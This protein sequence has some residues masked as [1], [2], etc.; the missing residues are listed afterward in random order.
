MKFKKTALLICAIIMVMVTSTL[1]FA[2]DKTD[3]GDFAAPTYADVYVT[4]GTMSKLL[5]RQSSIAFSDYTE[6]D[7]LR[8]VTVSVNT[9]KSY[10][11]FYGYGASLTH[12]SA[13]LLTQEGAEDIAEEMLQELFGTNGARLNLVRIPIGASDYIEGDE[14]FTCCDLDDDYDSDLALEHFSISHDTNLIKVLKRIMEINPDVK[15][16]ACPW[17]APAW[18]KNNHSLIGGK[19]AE[20]YYDVYAEYLVKFIEVYKE[21]GIEI[22]YLSLINE[23]YVT[24]VYPYMRMDAETAIPVGALVSQKLGA[25]GLSVKLLG[26]EHNVTTAAETYISAVEEENIFDGI[27]FHGYTDVK[28]ATISDGCDFMKEN[29]PDQEIFMTEITEHSG[30][31]DFASNLSYACRYTTVDPINHGLNGSMFWNLVLRSDGSPTNASHNTDCY[32]V[33]DMDY[34]DSEFTYSKNSAYYSMAH[35]SKFAYPINGVYPKALMTESSNATQIF[36]SALMRAD[37]AI[38]ITALNASDKLPENVHFEIN[39]QKVTVKVQPQSV[40]TIVC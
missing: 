2:C 11:E 27:S 40:V 16:F 18:M 28:R 37:G 12:S 15:V 21:Q 22:D 17:S 10:Q 32:G 31:M 7:E 8:G 39:G 14:W 9:D 26:W 19:L 4:T 5:S 35:I 25:K 29:Y 36:A 3:G 1:F 38:V 6:N 34:Q 13:Y 20:T 30:S 33:I 24:A 23:P